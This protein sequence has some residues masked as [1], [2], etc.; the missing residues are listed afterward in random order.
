MGGGGFLSTCLDRNLVQV[1]VAGKVGK[2]RMINHEGFGCFGGGELPANQAVGVLD[3]LTERI[4]TV[5]II[6]FVCFIQLTKGLVGVS[7]DD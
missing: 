5:S 1:V 3:A 2:C 6:W 7:G 4:V